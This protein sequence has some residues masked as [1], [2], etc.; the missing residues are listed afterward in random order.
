MTRTLGLLCIS[1]LVGRGMIESSIIKIDSPDLH[2]LNF[3]FNFEAGGWLN[4]RIE[5]LDSNS[6][7]PLYLFLCSPYEKNRLN[8]FTSFDEFCQDLEALS[9]RWQGELS[10]STPAIELDLSFEKETRME[11]FAVN[12]YNLN[13]YEVRVSSTAK[14]SYGYLSSNKLQYLYIFPLLAVLWACL[15]VVSLANWIPYRAFNVTIQK[16]FT[17]VPVFHGINNLFATYYWHWC[18]E[19]GH[20]PPHFY[21]NQLLQGLTEGYEYL[22]LM[23]IA[24]GYGILRPKLRQSTQVWLLAALLALSTAMMEIDGDFLFFTII[25]YLMVLKHIFNL[26]S[27][28]YGILSHQYHIM[29]E[30][31]PAHVTTSPLFRKVKLYQGFKKMVV[32]YIGMDIVLRW[33]AKGT[34]LNERWVQRIV[35]DALAIFFLSKIAWS[36]RMQPFAPGFAIPTANDMPRTVIPNWYPGM[37]VHKLP[38]DYSDWLNSDI[39]DLIVVEHPARRPIHQSSRHKGSIEQEPATTAR[40]YNIATWH[41]ER[42]QNSV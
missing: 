6:E 37:P 2:Y 26:Y 41:T 19:T 3:M 1:F 25:M 24:D 29:S 36:L 18:E 10:V 27:Q 20:I 17:G 38:E 9:C 12:C 34:N 11:F 5:L 35:E 42:V 8:K 22:V 30:R 39:A 33:W 14:N 15:L 31:Y 28:S 40:H 16:F 32:V 13:T 7:H 21:I 23:C 4:M